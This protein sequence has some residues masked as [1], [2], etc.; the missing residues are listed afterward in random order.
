M[1]NGVRLKAQKIGESVSGLKR[2]QL[3]LTR[4]PPYGKRTEQILSSR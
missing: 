1:Q 3:T 2:F 4:I